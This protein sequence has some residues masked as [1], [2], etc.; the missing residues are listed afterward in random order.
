[1]RLA[2]STVGFN[3]SCFY[4]M[5]SVDD[6][7]GSRTKGWAMEVELVTGRSLICDERQQSGLYNPV[8]AVGR[9]PAL[10]SHPTHL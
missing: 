2:L 6:R 3:V 9:C 1:M 5:M 10:D 8:A 4:T 7:T